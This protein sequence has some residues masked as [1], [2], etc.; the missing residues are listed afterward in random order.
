MKPRRR[1]KPRMV[2]VAPQAVMETQ[3]S[4]NRWKRW[5]SEIGCDWL[6]KDGEIVGIVCIEPRKEA[7]DE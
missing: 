5:G 1:Y 2:N 4:F 7:R 6:M 3:E